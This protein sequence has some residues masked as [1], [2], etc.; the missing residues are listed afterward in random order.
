VQ[1]VSAKDNVG[2]KSSLSAKE[3]A[4]IESA[5]QSITTKRSNTAPS[6]ARPAPASIPI[7]PDAPVIRI[8]ASPA[9]GTA[10]RIALLMKAEREQNEARK[11]NLRLWGI[12][13]PLGV[14]GMLVLWTAVTTLRQVFA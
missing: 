9:I 7:A 2:D 11:K 8:P 6:D 14:L 4:L 12:Y 1:T 13:V 5:R 10:E 3:R